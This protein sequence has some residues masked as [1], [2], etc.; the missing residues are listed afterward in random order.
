MQK[1]GKKQRGRPKASAGI[2][3]KNTKTGP[4]CLMLKSSVRE[5]AAEFNPLMESWRQHKLYA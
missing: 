5:W 1:G 2:P 3:L 4:L